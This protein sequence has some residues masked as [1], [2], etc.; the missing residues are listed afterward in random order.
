MKT[1]WNIVL[2]GL[3]IAASIAQAADEQHISKK[4]GLKENATVNQERINVC[5]GVILLPRSPSPILRRGVERIQAKA[6]YSVDLLHGTDLK[7]L[8]SRKYNWALVLN[9]KKIITGSKL[10]DDAWAVS[11]SGD[12]PKQVAIEAKTGRAQLFAMYHIAGCLELGKP[13]S[14]WP[15]SQS[16][17]VPKRYAWVTASKNYSP[18]FRPDWFDHDVAELPSMGYNGIVL[19][20]SKTE[21]TAIGL[22][23]IPLELTK[24]GVKIDRFKLPAFLQ[25]FNRLKSYGLDISLFFQAYTPPGFKSDDVRAYYDGKRKLSGLINAIK[26]SS[27]KMASALFVNMPQVDS[28]FFHSLECPWMWEGAISIYPAKNDKISEQAFDAYL[29]GLTRASK[30]YGKDLMFWTHVSG[31]SARQIRS[32]HRVLERFPSVIVIEDHAWPNDTWPYAPVMGHIYEEAIEKFTTGRWGMTIVTTDGEF[33]GAGALP[34]AFPDPHIRSA[35]AMV[36]YGAECG[37]VRLNQQNMTPL[38]T[39]RDCN[40]IHVIAVGEAWW[41]SPR[42]LDEQWHDWCTSRFGKSAAPVVIS[43]LKESETIIK[44]GLSVSDM[45]LLDHSGLSVH[46]WKPESKRLKCETFDRPGKLLVNKPYNQ[47]SSG[48]DFKAWQ[49]KARGIPLETYLQG[50]TE[51]RNTARNALKK[52][53]SVR[54]YLTADDYE[55][56]TRCFEDAILMIEVLRH[57]VVA[58]DA[59]KRCR[60][61][62]GEAERLELKK[63]CEAME[64]MA[65]KIELSRGVNFFKLKFF[66]RTRYKGKEYKGYGTP[67]ALRQLADIYRKYGIK[68]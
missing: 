46:V 36:K 27:Y 34:T 39:L 18:V 25:M 42:P 8:L 53:S 63:A 50:N 28:L 68:R 58:R 40:A 5:K 48:D 51:A 56:L 52:I 30:E 24:N 12:K 38:S 31:I 29:T 16:P 21:G 13:F 19:E 67:I 15:V 59:A 32:I 6:G 14:K 60:K 64:K 54:K 55:Y 65:D 62:G 3:L 43:V 20:C 37:I 33:F 47:L 4:T 10:G 57:T 41:S 9:D 22:Q 61:N 26:E 66:F 2:A 23:T 44:K 49:V 35:E 1:I 11:I 17:V 7:E 45:S